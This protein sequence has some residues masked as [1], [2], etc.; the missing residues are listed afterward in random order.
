MI[1]V[2]AGCVWYLEVGMF[3]FVRPLANKIK[4][5]I[6]RT[7][8]RSSVLGRLWPPFD[9][10]VRNVIIIPQ[11]GRRDT[12]KKKKNLVQY[13][14]W[15]VLISADFRHSCC[16]LQSVLFFF[17]FGLRGILFYFAYQSHGVWCS[18]YSE[19]FTCDAWKTE[20]LA[21][22]TLWPFLNAFWSLCLS[23]FFF[24]TPH[25]LRSFS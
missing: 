7:C 17:L 10:I 1:I 6:R 20:L 14:W 3:H 25:A 16:L 18:G 9:V 24:L 21:S 8:T 11:P 5:G 13:L 22:A 12:V 4:V 2:I 23:F 15:K 19:I